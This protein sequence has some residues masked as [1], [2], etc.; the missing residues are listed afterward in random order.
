MAFTDFGSSAIDR[1]LNIQRALDILEPGWYFK[2]V[3]STRETTC[4]MRTDTG[5]KLV[6]PNEYLALYPGTFSI[7]DDAV[8]GRPVTYGTQEELDARAN[9]FK[10]FLEALP[11]RTEQEILT[12]VQD[13]KD[14][15][16][17]GFSN[18]CTAFRNRAI[19]TKV[20]DHEAFMQ[21]LRQRIQTFDWSQCKVPGQAFISMD[22]AIPFVSC[23]NRPSKDLTE[24]HLV[25]RIHRRKPGVY[26]VRHAYGHPKATSVSVVLYTKD[27]YNTDPDVVKEGD[28]TTCDYVVVAVLSSCN[29]QQPYPPSVFVHNLAGGNKAFWPKTRPSENLASEPMDNLIADVNLLH[30]LIAEAKKCEEGKEGYILVAD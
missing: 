21:I 1:L 23:G 8:P 18:I 17:I 11:V 2:V 7:P 29:G 14:F 15:F 30:W 22:E 28:K 6:S 12:K 13:Q 5:Y 9:W 25:G 16:T 19:G 20:M 27:A 3:L 26:A 10:D 24:S 4:W